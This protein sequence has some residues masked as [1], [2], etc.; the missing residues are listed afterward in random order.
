M[1]VFFSRVLY[2]YIYIDIIWSYIQKNGQEN[3]R[4]NLKNIKKSWIW[5]LLG[6]D[7]N[8]LQQVLTGPDQVWTDSHWFSSKSDRFFPIFHVFSNLR[9]YG[10]ARASGPWKSDAGDH[11]IPRHFNIIA[12]GWNTGPLWKRMRLENGKAMKFNIGC[13]SM[14][15][16]IGNTGKI[17]NIGKIGNIFDIYNI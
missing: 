6:V 8:S 2:I 10:H 16:N 17:R 12:Y 11:R 9:V 5:D 4:K 3:V 7:F 13:A 1:K 15:R 14:Y